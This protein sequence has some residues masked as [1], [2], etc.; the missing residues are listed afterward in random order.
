MG[1]NPAFQFYPSDW[2]RDLEEHPLEI[3]GAW[4]RICCKLW[5]SETRGELSR[6]LDQW[7]KILRVG[8]ADAERIISYINSWEIGDILTGPNKN[9]TITCR[10]MLREEKSRKNNRERQKRHYEKRHNAVFNENLTPPSSSSSSLKNNTPPIAPPLGE[11]NTP[12]SGQD[13]TGNPKKFTDEFVSFWTAYPRKV[14]KDKAWEAWRRKKRRPPIS[15]LLEIIGRQKCSDEWTDMGGKFIPNPAT[16][17]NQ[18]RWQDQLTYGGGNGKSVTNRQFGYGRA[19][20]PGPE[21][22]RGILETSERLRRK[23]ES[24]GNASEVD[25]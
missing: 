25:S 16:W 21:I 14:G 11:P 24:P 5:W 18:G 1:K 22:D 17:L 7:A 4:I 19:Q 23:Y 12:G 8:V 3:E 10:R 2:T 13:E 9:I 6:T 15:E 20:G